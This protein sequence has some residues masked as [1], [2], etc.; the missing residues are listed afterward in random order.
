MC[1]R[2]G[3]PQRLGENAT[4]HIASMVGSQL[5]CSERPEAG[6]HWRIGSHAQF[7]FVRSCQRSL[8]GVTITTACREQTRPW[9]MVLTVT[10]QGIDKSVELTRV[11]RQAWR[12]QEGSLQGPCSALIGD[13][14][15]WYSM[16]QPLHNPSTA[17]DESSGICD[18]CDHH[19]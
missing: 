14:E 3:Q 16:W 13:L 2:T 6:Q 7:R 4:V 10:L 15:A 18:H 12:G 8:F 11:H 19:P 1:S 17:P 5:T 9:Q